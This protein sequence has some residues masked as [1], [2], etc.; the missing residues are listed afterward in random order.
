MTSQPT[1]TS[2]KNPVEMLREQVTLLDQMNQTQ[3]E[4][5]QVLRSLSEQ[6]AHL[7]VEVKQFA[8][9]ASRVRVEDFNMPFSSMVPFLFKRTF[10]L[11]IVS[12]TLGFISF[13][14]FFVF[15]IAVGSYFR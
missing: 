11:F 6:L 7:Q 13:C 3:Q 1:N 4:Q 12:I 9:S 8:Q 2:Q 15:M 10:A 5:L 14:I